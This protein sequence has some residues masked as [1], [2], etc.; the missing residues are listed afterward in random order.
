MKTSTKL[1]LTAAGIIVAFF[2]TSMF[3]I[4]EDL[5]AAI[6]DSKHYREYTAVD[7]NLFESITIQGD[8]FLRVRQDRDQKVEISGEQVD[9]SAIR[10]EDGTLMLESV[11][12]TYAIVTM[13]SIETLTI[14]KGAHL[15]MENFDMDSLQIILRDS[16][17][18][19][20]A[21]NVLEYTSFEVSGNSKI[22]LVDDP[23]Q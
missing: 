2:I 8:V 3:V 20:G 16:S 18:F 9:L 6:R 5:K 17:T 13:P 19:T 1:L 4:R 22:E 21:E 14:L 23:M 15:K 12:E 7:V 10:V 11:E